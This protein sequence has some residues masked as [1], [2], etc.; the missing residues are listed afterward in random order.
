MEENMEMENYVNNEEINN[1]EEQENDGLGTAAKA[2][3]VGGVV[4]A[5]V[6]AFFA[7]RA[8]VRK[9]KKTLEYARAYRE[10]HPDVDEKPAKKAKPVK[11]GGKLPEKLKKT[12]APEVIDVDPVPVPDEEPDEE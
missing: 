5:G 10:E 6:G 2:G 1:T 3:I 9:V 7:V 8:G 4:A 12:P 11:D